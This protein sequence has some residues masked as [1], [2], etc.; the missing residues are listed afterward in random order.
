MGDDF[1]VLLEGIGDE[2]GRPLRLPPLPVGLQPFPNQRPKPH[3][4][5]SSVAINGR[6]YLTEGDVESFLT[7]APDGYVM[8]GLWGY[9]INS[10]AFYYCS[11]TP[12]ARIFL[13][14][15]YGGV[16]MGDREAEALPAFFDHFTPFLERV[17]PIVTSLQLVESMGYSFRRF[18]L[19][20][21][22]V[23]EETGPSLHKNV[24][25]WAPLEMRLTGSVA[26][27]VW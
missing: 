23:V 22:R 4:F 5:G 18:H 11:V 6:P 13:R 1:Q 15:P 26:E 16:Y 8:L 12:E 25:H 27:S 20:S 3:L 14:L 7:K 9:G 19:R 21:G 10:Y 2:L 17:C 24:D